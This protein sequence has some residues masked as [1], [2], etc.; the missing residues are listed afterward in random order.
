MLTCAHWHA[1][2]GEKKTVP[3]SLD[4]LAVGATCVIASWG[5][6]P[7]DVCFN[8]MPLFHT[9]GIVRNLLSPVLAGGATVL[10][11]GFDAAQFWDAGPRL[12]VTWCAA[13]P[14]QCGGF[15]VP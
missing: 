11:P 7:S 3:Y 5:L 13:I 12:G 6:G 10:A 2:S 1:L 14:T 8:T 15:Q 9:G 4:T